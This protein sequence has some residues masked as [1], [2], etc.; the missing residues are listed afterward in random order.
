MRN[1]IHFE[2][3]LNLLRE[4]IY[5]TSTDDAHYDWSLDAI[6]WSVGK[7]DNVHTVLDVGCGN[8]FSHLM[9]NKYGIEYTGVTLGKDD[10][11]IAKHSN[12]NVVEMDMSFLQF[13]TEKF[14]IVYSRHS[15]EH[16]PFPLLTLMEWHRVSKQ[17]L[18]LVLPSTEYWGIGGRN[19]YSVFTKDQ[20][21]Y[22]FERSG[23]EVIASHDF[24]STDT[25]WV[26]HHVDHNGTPLEWVGHPKPIEYRYILRKI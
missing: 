20:W 11:S 17:Y 21:Y 23:W 3:Y 12:F 4:D 7:C 26:K 16:S 22:V 2:H 25:L 19:H 6:N 15:L 9:F 13:D 14:D 5:P 10:L 24:M 1:Y 8:G 18:I